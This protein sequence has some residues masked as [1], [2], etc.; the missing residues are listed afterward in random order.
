MYCDLYFESGQ[1]F[2]TKKIIGHMI[3]IIINVSVKYLHLSAYNI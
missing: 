2:L 3:D 1:S